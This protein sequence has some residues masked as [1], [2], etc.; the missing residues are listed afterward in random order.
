MGILQAIPAPV[1]IE[2]ERTTV[3][4]VD[5]QNAALSAGGIFDLIGTDISRARTAIEPMRRVIAGVRARG[6]P[7]IYIQHQYSPDFSELG[8]PESVLWIKSTSLRYYREHPEWRDRLLVQDTWGAAIITELAPEPDDIVLPKTR[9]SAFWNTTLDSV[10]RASR[11]RYLAVIGVWANVCV[12]ATARD[13]LNFG[14]YPVFVRD[15]VGASSAEALDA[16][17]AS[18]VPAFSWVTTTDDLLTALT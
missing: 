11:T 7:V 16:T 1:E 18:L 2:S 3:V 13:A 9:Y 17:V 8:D 6:R 4:I 12:S 15:A 10:L 5:V 14:Y